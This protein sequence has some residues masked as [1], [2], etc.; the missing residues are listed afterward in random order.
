MVGDEG[1]SHAQARHKRGG[2]QSNRSGLTSR[3][4][5]GQPARGGELAE[6]SARLLRHEG[7]QV[8]V[9]VGR[10]RILGAGALDADRVGASR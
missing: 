5:A 3:S 6:S 4:A 9:G 7:V 2:M 8:D 10:C 1:E